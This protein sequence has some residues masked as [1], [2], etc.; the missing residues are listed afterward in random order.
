MR[1]IR[2]EENTQ[3]TFEDSKFDKL[4]LAIGSCECHGEHLPF[5]CDSLVSHQIALDLAERFDDAVVAPPL[6]FGMS[7]HYRHQPMCLSLSDDTVIRVV[8]E[9]LDSALYWGIKKVLIVNGHDGNIAPIEI[10]ARDF[11]VQNPD[12]GLAVLD[13]WWVTAGNLLPENT[14]EV[15]NGLGHGGEGETSIG[16]S[17]FPDL[18]DM[19]RAKGQVPEFDTNVKLIW[20]FDE[21]TPYGASG[22]PTKATKEKGDAM[23]QVLV[24]Y[25]EKY[26]RHMD[27]QNWRY[28]VVK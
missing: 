28:G 17:I 6:W 16:L 20:N 18:C 27:A 7:Q 4:F 9:L 19:D 22:D 25:L 26:I 11:K 13:A 24:D 23:R 21:L 14:F 10:A 8:R 1:N 3:F 12:F 2:L 15:W 5:G